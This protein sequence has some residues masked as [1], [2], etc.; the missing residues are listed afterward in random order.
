MKIEKLLSALLLMLALFGSMSLVV[1][2]KAISTAGSVRPLVNHGDPH[3]RIDVYPG[4]YRVSRGPRIYSPTPI[5][6]AVDYVPP[7]QGSHY[8]INVHH[9]TYNEYVIIDST[10][11]GLT[12][13]GRRAILN[14]TGL[15]GFSPTGQGYYCG[16][17]VWGADYVTIQ[18]FIIQNYLGDGI[19]LFGNYTSGTWIPAENNT[20]RDNIIDYCATG[21]WPLAHGAIH[22]LVASSNLIERN[23]V[24]NSSAP[25]ANIP[26]IL[27]DVG[28]N[29]VIRENTIYN[30][31]G[32]GIA[33]V[34]GAGATQVFWNRIISNGRVSGDGLY[35]DGYSGDLTIVGNVI[36][37]N[38]YGS[39]TGDGML[40][41]SGSN[42]ISCNKVNGNAG[43][44]ILMLQS[45]YSLIQFNL[46]ND[47]GEY[48]IAVGLP[49]SPSNYNTIQYN[50]AYGNGLFDLHDGGVGNTWT[51]NE[52]GTFG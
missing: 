23:T 48:G 47:N 6:A 43:S 13:Q 52:Y 28:S 20:V 30:N 18:H 17:T 27:V 41:Y 25:S 12:L 24:E 32:T 9:G 29:N 34:A 26:G 51:D 21:S 37:S 44:G 16:F 40:I 14:G 35:A 10:K 46:V 22:L 2:V 11:S 3:R 50:W 7:G 19:L 33:L 4:Y 5:Q 31:G 42:T 8:V 45:G 49:F 39:P 38:G 36:D 1:S 15:S